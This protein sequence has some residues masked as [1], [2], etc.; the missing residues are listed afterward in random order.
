MLT[1]IIKPV[2]NV[3]NLENDRIVHESK[4]KGIIICTQVKMVIQIRIEDWWRCQI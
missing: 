4:I 1:T 2:E 3:I